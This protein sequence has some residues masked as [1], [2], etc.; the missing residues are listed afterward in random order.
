MNQGIEFLLKDGTKDSYD[1][2]YDLEETDTHY[3]VQT[4]Y[5]YEIEKVTVEGYNYYDLCDSCEHDK[6]YCICL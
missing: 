6:R 5:Q 1:P 3:I 2:V 4:V